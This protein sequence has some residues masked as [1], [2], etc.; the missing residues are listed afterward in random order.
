MDFQLARKGVDFGRRRKKWIVLLTALGFTGYGV[1]TVYNLPSV[2]KKRRK[3]SKLLGAL[4][5]VAEAV[6]DSADSLGIVSRDLKEFLR[7]D[8]DEIPNSLKQLSKIASSDE[9]STSLTK[10]TQVLTVGILR[11]YRKSNESD[12]KSGF[13][14]ESGSNLVDRAM[15]KILSPSGTGFASVVVG[16]FARNLILGFYS[17]QT[18]KP[19]NFPPEW[20]ELLFSEK[21]R[22]LIGECIQAFVGTAVAVYLEKTMDVNTYDQL[23]SG[24]TNPAHEAQIKDVVVSVCNGAVDTLV[25]TS[26]GVLTEPGPDS[27][28][29][30]LAGRVSTTLAVPSNRKLVLDLTGRVTFETVRSFLEFL[31]ERVLEGVKRCVHV[32]HESVVERGLWVLRYVA[33][34]SAL[35]ATI[36]VSLCLHATGGSSWLL[37]P[38]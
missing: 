28:S 32:A 5:S 6:S 14:S 9:F 21:S 38:A 10:L 30:G 36:C 25:R 31:V 2:A 15:D 23:F 37:L 26:H 13:G 19:N 20:A 27:G 34:K 3:I 12:E 35:I 29:G 24:L 22:S 4:I 7:S 8:S 33:A 1:Y 18:E 17:A 11:G 16:S